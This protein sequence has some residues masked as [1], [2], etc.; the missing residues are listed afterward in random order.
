MDIKVIAT[1][2][3]NLLDMK[4][5]KEDS[6]KYDDNSHFVRKE[7]NRREEQIKDEEKNI[8]NQNI[9]LKTYDKIKQ[10]RRQSIIQN[11]IA[12]LA[13]STMAYMSWASFTFLN[14]HLLPNSILALGTIVTGSISA[15]MIKKNI[16]LN[17][18]YKTLRNRYYY[19]KP[20]SSIKSSEG[21]I[22]KLKDEINNLNAQLQDINQSIQIN[23][24]RIEHLNEKFNIFIINPHNSRT[25]NDYVKRYVG[26]QESKEVSTAL[27]NCYDKKRKLNS[28]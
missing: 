15:I 17:N 1:L 6:K 11:I 21:N 3:K 14:G 18:Y 23:N 26:N 19:F 12:I 4:E 8:E 5:A 2:K 20:E 13:F 24:K 16:S 27:N 10:Q 9:F 28:K 25:I 7:I 22:I